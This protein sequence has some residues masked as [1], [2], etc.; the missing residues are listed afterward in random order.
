MKTRL[1][2]LSFMIMLAAVQVF[3]GRIYL[4]GNA[5]SSGWSLDDAPLMEQTGDNV[6]QWVGNLNLQPEFKN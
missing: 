6:Y 4:I 3:A 5:T 1:F 2:S